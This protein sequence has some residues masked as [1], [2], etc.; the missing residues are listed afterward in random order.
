MA[1]ALYSDTFWFPN[2]VLA[3]LISATVFPRGN[4]APAQ[5]W[6]DAAGTIPLDNPVD[7]DSFGTLTFYATVGEYWVHLD[8][9]TFLIDVGMS[10]EQSDL[11]TGV[12]SG[13]RISINAGNNK[14]IDIT[15]LVGYVVSN[16]QTGPQSP[17][18][19]RV[20][21]P[22]ATVVLDAAAQTRPLTWWVM[23]S[24]QVITQLPDK[25]PNSQRRTHLV[26]GA[27]FYDTVAGSLITAQSL[28]VILPQPSN[29][30]VDL[31]D[32]LGPFSMSG[33][34]ISPNGAN[35]MINKSSGV[36]FSRSFNR[37]SGASLTEDPHVTSSAALTPATL[38][39]TI[40]TSISTPPLVATVDPANYDLN[41]VLTPV[42][43][44]TNSSTVQR[45]FMFANIS[46][47]SSIIVQYGQTTY[48]SLSNA[49]ASIGNT[50]YV[51]APFTVN[52]TFLGHIAMI[53]T[54]T[55]L[56]D[57]V[58]ASFIPA[59]KFGTP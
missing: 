14:A 42:G 52:A 39:R 12:S 20:D 57:P 9:E 34:L 58:Q 45:V 4:S 44:G 54:A 46:P 2:G 59:G 3:S 26:L 7:T 29:Q 28:P 16:N 31:M 25:P 11:S 22:G 51:A 17:T 33:N 27:T 56:S 37:F 49:I 5:L 32:G 10:Q 55:N 23:D 30:V 21:Y 38:R 35:L 36:F 24:N 8:S 1:L 48:T 18:I 50:S 13:G 53:R 40:R 43:G 6:A 41:G 19:S 47:V 15:P